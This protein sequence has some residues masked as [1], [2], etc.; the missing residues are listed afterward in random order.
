M[1]EGRAYLGLLGPDHL[2]QERGVVK[3]A[4]VQPAE[5]DGGEGKRGHGSQTN[6][7]TGWSPGWK[8]AAEE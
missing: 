5:R 2:L 3:E 1:A 6:P 7:R 8:R 4:G